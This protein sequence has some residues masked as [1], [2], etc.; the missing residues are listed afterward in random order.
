MQGRNLVAVRVRVAMTSRGSAL[1]GAVALV[2]G[3]GA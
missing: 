1:Y 3:E 2:R